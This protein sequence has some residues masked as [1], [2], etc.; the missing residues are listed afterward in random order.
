MVSEP[1][2]VTLSEISPVDGICPVSEEMAEDNPTLAESI[3]PSTWSAASEPVREI[4]PDR[5][6]DVRIVIGSVPG[7][8]VATP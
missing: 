1:S 3:A 7:T 8:A 6:S 4:C 5:S 2:F